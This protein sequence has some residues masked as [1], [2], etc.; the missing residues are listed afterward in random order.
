MTTYNVIQLCDFPAS[1][2]FTQDGTIALTF[3]VKVKIKIQIAA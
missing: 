3:R 2:V 1:V